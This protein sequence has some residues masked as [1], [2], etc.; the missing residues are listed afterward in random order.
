MIRTKDLILR[1]GKFQLGPIDLTVNPGEYFVLL[2]LPGSGKSLLLESVCGLKRTDAG[3]VW[4]DGTDA[5]RLEPRERRISYVPQDYALF[6]HLSVSGNIGFGLKAWHLSAGENARRVGETAEMLGISHLLGRRIDGLSGGEKQRVALGRA[7][8]LRSKILLL[9]EP[10]SA[11]ADVIRQEVCTELRRL[12]RELDL[13]IM[14]VSHNLEEA[15]LVA[16]RAAVM[17][18][19]RLHQA[20]TMGELLRRPKDAFV[21]RFMRCENILCSSAVDRQAADRHM[22]IRPEHIEVYTEREAVNRRDDERVKPHAMVLK[23][24]SD[25]GSYFRLEMN[26]ELNLTAHLSP[27]EWQRLGAREGDRLLAVLPP[28]RLHDLLP[29]E[30]PAKSAGC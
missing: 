26:G 6:P 30:P 22:M 12:Q 19:G 20:G 28:E 14:H 23:H 16:D 11:L 18:D 8:V 7:L 10:V 9:D 15:F 5:T 25:C 17:N 29:P 13:T 21:A 27:S 3:R 4:L 24:Y 1:V 2:G